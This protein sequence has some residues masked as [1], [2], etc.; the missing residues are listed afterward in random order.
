MTSQP[1]DILAHITA[2]KL[3]EIAA[4]KAARPLAQVMDEAK[5]IRDAGDTPRGF[6][7]ALKTKAGQNKP[8]LIAEIKRPAPPKVLF[9]PTLIHP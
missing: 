3:E 2:Y 4:A 6:I 5:A 9:A 8:A 7:E 1:T